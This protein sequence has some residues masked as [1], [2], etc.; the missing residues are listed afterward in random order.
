M[1]KKMCAWTN[2]KSFN[3]SNKDKTSGTPSIVIFHVKY[4]MH[5]K[6][7]NV[8]PAIKKPLNLINKDETF[9]TPSSIFCILTGTVITKQICCAGQIKERFF[10]PNLNDHPHFKSLII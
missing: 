2:R 8:F 7:K 6:W 10:S 4:Y 5:A 1:K 3:V 9:S